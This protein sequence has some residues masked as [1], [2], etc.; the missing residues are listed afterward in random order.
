MCKVEIRASKEIGCA[1]RKSASVR[2]YE[3]NFDLWE[4]Q[5]AFYGIS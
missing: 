5:G 1:V 3:I 2:W 4:T